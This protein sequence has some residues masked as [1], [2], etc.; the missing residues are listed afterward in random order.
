MDIQILNSL[1]GVRRVLGYAAMGVMVA[2][3]VARNA[4]AVVAD[5]SQEVDGP[6]AIQSLVQA[7]ASLNRGFMP[8]ADLCRS[9]QREAHQIIH[10]LQE[11][12]TQ[13]SVPRDR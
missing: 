6:D 12:G 3:D 2:P 13:I 9:G 5:V 4:Q 1:Q 11:R 8:A 7:V 10:T